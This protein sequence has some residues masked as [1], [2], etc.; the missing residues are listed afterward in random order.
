MINII[1][2]YAVVRPDIVE[3]YIGFAGCGRVESSWSDIDGEYFDLYLS[4]DDDDILN[5]VIMKVVENF[6]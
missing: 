5:Y 6:M 3:G 4:C 1:L 2:E